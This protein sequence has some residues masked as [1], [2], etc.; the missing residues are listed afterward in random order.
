[1]VL[2]NPWRKQ[3][4]PRRRHGGGGTLPQQLGFGGSPGADADDSR[5]A[6]LLDVDEYGVPRTA[7]NAPSGGAA[8]RPGSG[9]THSGSAGAVSDS[10][11]EAEDG[12]A[13]DDDEGAADGMVPRPG[14]GGGGGGGGE[15]VPAVTNSSWRMYK[16]M[17]DYAQLMRCAAGW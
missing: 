8:S 2:G 11:A 10:E 9:S 12:T 3:R 16:W 6:R 14:G 17:R 15:Q 5:G 4:S 1:V 13:A 7:S